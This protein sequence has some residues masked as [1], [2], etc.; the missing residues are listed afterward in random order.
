LA[1]FNYA[2]IQTVADR[3]I[4]RFGY[5]GHILRNNT[6]TYPCK[7]VLTEYTALEVDGVLI[8][9]T[10][11]KILIAAKNLNIEPN[12][13]TDV[14]FGGDTLPWRII[15]ANRT[16]PGGVNLLWELQVRK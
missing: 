6:T 10:D 2:K 11:R 5:S 1:G 9:S 13:E 15:R 8:Q 12:P 14:V 7:L 4:T 3:L 16:A